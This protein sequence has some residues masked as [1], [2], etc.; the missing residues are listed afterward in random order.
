M[1][2]IINGRAAML[3][4]DFAEQAKLYLLAKNKKYAMIP[5]ITLPSKAIETI[6]SIV[7][8]QLAFFFAFP[9][10]PSS[11]AAAF[12]GSIC[13]SV[14]LISISA[15]LRTINFRRIPLHP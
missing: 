14:I 4:A 6:Q 10:E 13:P 2:A 3:F 5:M 15:S 9:S 11:L 7:R 1:R 12:L 8:D